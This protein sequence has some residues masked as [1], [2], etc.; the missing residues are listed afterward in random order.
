MASETVRI[1][2]SAGH[3]LAAT[4]E[5]PAGAQLGAAVFAHCFTCT[6]Q[7][8]AAVAVSR[9]LA[10]KGVACLRFDFT[11]LGD[12]EGDF[13]ADSFPANI[14]DVEAAVRWLADRSG[15][16]VLLIGHSLGGAAV[17]GASVRHPS[18]AAVATIGAPASVEHVLH[19]I[20]GDLPAIEREGAGPVTIGGRGFTIT[21]QFLANLR[22]IDLTAAVHDLD[23]P[24]MILHSPTDQLVGIDNAARLFAAARHPKSFVSLAGADHLLL[25]EADAD[26]AAAVI[27]AWASRYFCND[28]R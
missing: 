22:G 1:V 2:T 5:I 23:R 3:A 24:L 17:L 25:K 12:S 21:R 18:V 9:E 16:D 7:S 27:A 6:R 4:L 8:K 15:Q 10:G 28:R 13:G 11:G 20:H 14:C 19:Q 26:F